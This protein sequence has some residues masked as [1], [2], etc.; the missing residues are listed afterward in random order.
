MQVEEYIEKTMTLGNKTPVTNIDYTNFQS[1]SKYCRLSDTVNKHVT[2][3]KESIFHM[4]MLK[5]VEKFLNEK[6]KDLSVQEFN[7]Y[8][9][10]FYILGNDK[11]HLRNYITIEG[12]IIKDESPKYETEFER[13]YNA[14]IE[15]VSTTSNNSE[16]IVMGF[17]QNTLFRDTYSNFDHSLPQVYIKNISITS[18][19]MET[20]SFD[21][22]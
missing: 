12:V 13:E 16:K 11:F 18:F 22:N 21:E 6:F 5:E 10:N 4:N 19:F 2:L 14:L 3:S 8:I 15:A 7:D 9:S 1:G 20:L 17:I